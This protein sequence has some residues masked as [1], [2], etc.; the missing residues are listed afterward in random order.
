MFEAGT[1]DYAVSFAAD[2]TPPTVSQVFP[3]NG[4]TDVAGGTNV[5]VTFS[6]AMNAST[7]TTNTIT[8]W[9]ATNNAVPATV[10][11]NPTNFTAILQPNVPLGH[12]ETYTAKVVGGATGVKD[13]A[14][15]PLASRFSGPSPRVME[16]RYPSGAMQRFP[17]SDVRSTT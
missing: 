16:F 1:G 11:Y 17:R 4:A 12:L 15:N 10:S 13:V 14:G 9:D 2:T 5:T 6:E 7:I 8:L 3:A